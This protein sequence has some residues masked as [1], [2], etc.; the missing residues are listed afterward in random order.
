MQIKVFVSIGKHSDYELTLD[1]YDLPENTY[2]DDRPIEKSCT[3]LRA[4]V[5]IC[6]DSMRRAT[7]KLS[8]VLL[9]HRI[10]CCFMTGQF[11][12]T[13]HQRTSFICGAGVNFNPAFP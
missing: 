12:N 13:E 6:V 8:A 2:D 7:L 5:S 3:A 10:F 9:M 4:C 11:N 1:I